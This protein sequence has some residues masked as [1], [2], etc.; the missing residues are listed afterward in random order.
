MDIIIGKDRHRGNQE[1]T[2][3]EKVE[4][5]RNYKPSST[6]VHHFDSTTSMQNYWAENASH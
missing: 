6:L 5:Q 2:S 1:N 4:K 3:I